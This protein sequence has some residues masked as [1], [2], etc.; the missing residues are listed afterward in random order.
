[1]K[2]TAMI[3]L[4]LMLGLSACQQA[5]LPLAGAVTG[6]A[7]RSTVEAENE[8]VGGDFQIAAAKKKRPSPTPSP[9]L[10][11]VPTATP[12]AAP[13]S[14]P[15]AE[16]T[17]VPTLS[18]TP[19]PV[20]TPVPTPIPTAPPATGDLAIEVAGW[21]NDGWDAESHAVYSKYKTVFS[22]VNPYWYNLGTDDGGLAAEKIDGS[23]YERS[24][25]YNPTEVSQ[26]HSNGDLI[27]PTIGDN[28]SGQLNKILASS[29]ARQTLINNLVNTAVSRGYDGF[30]LNFE[31]GQAPGQAAYALFVDDLAKQLHS[32]G[33]RLSVTLKAAD[34][35]TAEG[36]EIFDYQRL[37]QTAADRF[38]I[39]MYDHNFDAGMNVPG[40]IGEYAWIVA[41]LDYM[42]ARGLPA[43]KIQ[44]GL[45]NYAW[46]W[47]KESSGSY[48]MQF[49][50]ST[51]SV[52]S[53]QN[54]SMNWNTA[55]RE[56]WKD[57]SSGTATYR[58]YVGDARTVGERL[59]LVRSYGLAGVTFWTLGRED[60]SIYPNLATRYPA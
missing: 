19:S 49:P 13:S 55:A 47:R 32:V 9:S 14:E 21:Y 52:V 56:S 26:V 28:A 33:K 11:P 46:V 30:D 6:P 29:T 38:K 18:P 40:P 1:M 45:H 22:E 5:P 2:R 16:P 12:T 27:L 58:S 60:Q 7:T 42:I 51:F 23:I 37:G 20:A 3:C 34:S 57:Y 44:L 4:T 24:Y 36:R 41:S 17:T 35:S 53:Q 25:A 10:S 43:G 8:M 39:M 59:E 31:L 50:H 54:G 48:T 15:S